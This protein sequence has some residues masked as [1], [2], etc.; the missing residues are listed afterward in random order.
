MSI[1]ESIEDIFVKGKDG[2][3]HEYYYNSDETAGEHIVHNVIGINQI[4]EAE[5]FKD[6][7]SE[8]FSYLDSCCKTYLTDIDKQNFEEYVQEIK[9]IDQSD[10]ITNGT[11]DNAVDKLLHHAYKELLIQKS[12]LEMKSFLTDLENKS[13][14]EVIESAYELT[15]KNEMMFALKDDSLTNE[16][17][18]TLA[19]CDYPLEKCYRSWIK[20]DLS[21]TDILQ[22]SVAETANREIEYQRSEVDLDI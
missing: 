2:K 8:F 11:D 9:D 15:M 21:Y 22:A 1:A 6:N 4:I 14:K 20:N 5:Y 19:K 18:K 16:Q 17:I 10:I 3:I 13:P 7:Q 12:N